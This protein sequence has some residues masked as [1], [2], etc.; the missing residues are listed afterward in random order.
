MA[1]KKRSTK[2]PTSKAKNAYD[3]LTDIG[4]LALEEP[5]RMRM[6]IWLVRGDDLW[7]FRDVVIP[8]CGTIGCIGGWTYVLRPGPA[9][10]DTLGLTRAME[11]QLFYNLA[12]CNDI[13]QGTLAHSERVVAHIKRFQKKYAKRLKAKAV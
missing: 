3:L 9:V 8:A 11:H 13:D 12:L 5:K 4:K 10:E 1:D 2:L 7:L 6:G